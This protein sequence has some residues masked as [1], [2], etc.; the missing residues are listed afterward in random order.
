M[1]S[2]KT[3]RF[4][5]RLE[6][7]RQ[8]TLNQINSLNVELPK[9]QE[10]IDDCQ[11]STS[12]LDVDALGI[13][14]Q[15]NSLK[16]QIV[17]IGQSA[18]IIVG[19]ASSTITTVKNDSLVANTWNASSSSY[20]GTDPFGSIISTGI[21]TANAGLGTITVHL[22]DG[23]SSIGTYYTLS[24]PGLTSSPSGLPVSPTPTD[25]VNCT[26]CKNAITNLQNQ[27]ASL[28]VSIGSTITAING[29]KYQKSEY[30]L[31]RYALNRG[32]VQKQ[33]IVT[34]VSAALTTLYD[35]NNN[36]RI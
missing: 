30:E 14:S 33:D 34:K 27:V 12:V 9:V 26:N 18:Q 3:N 21:T 10:Y 16:T 24:G 7:K 36:N 6:K 13:L 32:I 35:P 29:L 1:A 23:G 20:T 31:T 19:C 2:E 8:D 11:P 17:S 25:N 15:I 22:P 4:A 5:E 28:R